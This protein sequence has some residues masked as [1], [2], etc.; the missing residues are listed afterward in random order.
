[1]IRLSSQLEYGA[2]P[3]VFDRKGLTPIMK[4]CRMK[5]KG[6]DAIEVVFAILCSVSGI[7]C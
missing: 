3:N 7:N 5:D 2:S 4:A 1:M 6:I